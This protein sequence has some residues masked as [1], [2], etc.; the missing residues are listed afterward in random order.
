MILIADC[1]A[2]PR[3]GNE[4]EF[5]QLLDQLARTRH[6]VVFLGDILDFWI[7]LPGYEKELHRHFLQWCQRESGRRQVGFVEG[8]HEFFV[9]RQ[10][11]TAFSFCAP[12]E[13]VDGAGRLFIH[14]DTI[15]RADRSQRLLRAVVKSRLICWAEQVVPGAT[16]VAKVIKSHFES[17]RPAMAKYYPEAQVQA[18]VH[19]WFARGVKAVYM[20]HFHEA[21]VVEAP[22]GR[23]CQVV[24][25]WCGTDLVGVIPEGGGPA[26]IR[27]CQEIP[28]ES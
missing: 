24:P 4:A 18:F 1:H 13:H 8:N 12:D 6:D 2:S 7:A 25:P 23:I 15:N 26:E 10:H 19:A 9:A 5:A 14:G 11:A 17:R 28:A 21:R 3:R 27:R 22:P 16:W 20:G